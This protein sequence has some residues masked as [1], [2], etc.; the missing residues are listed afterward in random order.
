MSSVDEWATV[1]PTPPV[2]LHI[3][4]VVFG[5][6]RGLQ[7]HSGADSGAAQRQKAAPEPS[8]RGS[9]FIDAGQHLKLVGGHRLYT[10]LCR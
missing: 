6:G 2:S 7:V 9:F 1:H 4:S 5:E 8:L 10:K 3:T